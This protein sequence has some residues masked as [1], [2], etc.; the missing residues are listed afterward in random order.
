M[1]LK[2]NDKVMAYIPPVKDILPSINLVLD[3]QN[4]ETYSVNLPT[5]FLH[6]RLFEITRSDRKYN[7]STASKIQKGVQTNK[8][9]QFS[10]Q[11][12]IQL[13]GSKYSLFVE[14]KHILLNTL[15]YD[16]DNN[17]KLSSG[18]INSFSSSLNHTGFNGKLMRMIIPDLVKKYFTLHGF[19][20]LYFITP[21]RTRVDFLPVLFDSVEYHLYKCSGNE[22]SFLAIDSIQPESLVDFQKKCFNILLAYGFITGNLIHDECYILSFSDSQMSVPEEFLYHSMRSGVISNQPVFTANPF[23]VNSD[24]DFERDDE[25]RIKKDITDKLYEGM[26]DLPMTVFSGI[27][28]LFLRQEKLQRAALLFIQSHLTSLEMRIPNYYVALEAITG[29]ISSSIATGKRSLAPI[30]DTTVAAALI[31]KIK[32]EAERIKADM[33]LDDEE[34]NMAVFEKNINKLNAPPNADK[35]AESFTHIGYTLSEEEKKILKD[36]N[37][38]LHGSFLKTVDDDIAFREALHVALRVHFLIAVALLKLGGFSGKIINYAELWSH[39][40]EK[41]LNEERLVKI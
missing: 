22:N 15:S 19:K 23:S 33:S 13:K 25:G 30:K 14:G 16:F 5:H 9:I 31:L 4:P 1:K 24:M 26:D 36:R 34:F 17:L 20:H 18:S 32:E 10:R 38:F 28:N 39:I 35:L 21:K 27:A 29:F 7:Y 37:T 2:T 12:N 41:E 3:L 11:E 8:E 6:E 40:T